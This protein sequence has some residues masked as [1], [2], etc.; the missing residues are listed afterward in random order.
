MEL[1]VAIHQIRITLTSYNMKFLEG[2][3]TD[4]IRGTKAKAN[5]KVKGLVQM[6]TK[7]KTNYK[8]NSL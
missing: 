5:L 3:C 1:E 6:P 4:L 8:E 7:T 2:V